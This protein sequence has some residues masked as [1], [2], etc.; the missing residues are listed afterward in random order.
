MLCIVQGEDEPRR[1]EKE[2]SCKLQPYPEDGS[3]YMVTDGDHA[4]L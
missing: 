4:V 2:C 1:R 3:G